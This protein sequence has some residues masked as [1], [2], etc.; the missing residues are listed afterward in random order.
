LLQAAIQRIMERNIRPDP[1]IY[2]FSIHPFNR[3][4][5]KSVEYKQPVEITSFS[6]D[7]NRQLHMDDRELVSYIA[8][9]CCL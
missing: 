3:F 4:N 5:K 8:F 1:N 2:K 9:H 6:Y 7:E